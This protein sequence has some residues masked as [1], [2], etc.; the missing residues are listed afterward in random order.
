MAT[1]ETTNLQLVKSGAGTDNF[2]RT[3]YNGNLDKI[4]TFAGNTNQAI[5]NLNN[6]IAT[7]TNGSHT[8]W[9]T[10]SQNAYQGTYFAQICGNFKGKTI[11][12]DVITA[13]SGSSSY[14][15]T[16]D[17]TLSVID[18]MQIN[19]ATTASGLGGCPITV[20]VTVS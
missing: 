4:D 13:L 11:T 20:K 19:I 14:N 15:I 1:S 5:A 18:D 6:Q 3:D 2:I 17:T 12:K 8:F 7:L 9:A 16:N 10:L